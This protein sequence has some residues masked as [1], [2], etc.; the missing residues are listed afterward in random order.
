MCLE[1]RI[2]YS[3][4]NSVFCFIFLLYF[5]ILLG[6][7]F[8]FVFDLKWPVYMIMFFLRM[9]N[10]I[11][12]LLA[13]VSFHNLLAYHSSLLSLY[14]TRIDFGLWGK[15]IQYPIRFTQINQFHL[16]SRNIRDGWRAWVRVDTGETQGHKTNW[17][18]H[19][20]KI[21]FIT[22]RVFAIGSVTI[23]RFLCSK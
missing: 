14:D 6:Y 5:T 16:Q 8:S 22:S 21:G 18:C 9:F 15:T 11:W 19:Y 10:V 1:V 2:R 13:C 7:L 20:V 23:M 17:K 3:N 4:V 12:L